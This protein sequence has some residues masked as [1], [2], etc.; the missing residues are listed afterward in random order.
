[1]YTH[2]QGVGGGCNARCRQPAAIEGGSHLCVHDE[3]KDEVNLTV[4]D[5]KEFSTLTI[6]LA[7]ATGFNT[8]FLKVMSVC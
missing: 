5:P 6:Y 8:M 3:K 7:G 1:M 2:Q 4:C